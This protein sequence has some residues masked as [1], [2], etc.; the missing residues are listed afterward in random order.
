M[1]QERRRGEKN[2]N[3][4][5]KFTGI[6]IFNLFSSETSIKLLKNEMIVKYEILEKA[7][8]KDI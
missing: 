6:S 5:N 1:K 8:K 7:N 4:F 2:F 3:D